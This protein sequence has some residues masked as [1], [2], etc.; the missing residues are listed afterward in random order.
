M[1]TQARLRP[2][3]EVTVDCGGLPDRDVM[4]NAYRLT[5]PRVIFEVLSPTTRGEDKGEKPA[6]Y[7]AVSTLRM[8]A[9]VDPDTRC[10][11]VARRAPQPRGW[12]GVWHEQPVGVEL[13]AAGLPLT[14]PYA[15]IFAR[16]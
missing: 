6:E 4:L 3:T 13:Q 1:A 5:D 12:Q 15:E 11:F 8:V 2:I 7:Q 9:L 16:D 10:L 14:L